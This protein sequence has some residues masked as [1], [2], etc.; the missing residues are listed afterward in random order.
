MDNTGN[1]RADV[2]GYIWMNQLMEGIDPNNPH[3]INLALVGINWEDVSGKIKSYPVHDMEDDRQKVWNW[4]NKE[5]KEWTLLPSPENFEIM[6][7]A[8]YSLRPKRKH[9]G[10]EALLE[11]QYRLGQHLEEWYGYGQNLTEGQFEELVELSERLNLINHSRAERL[12]TRLQG[13]EPVR[14]LRQSGQLVA[15]TARQTVAS[16][17]WW[18]GT[19]YELLK[20]LL[21]F[22]AT[23]K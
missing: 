21:K 1:P 22:I 11:L 14:T 5:F 10:T 2:E 17:G 15:E 19:V 4:Y 16:P 18:A 20:T 12:V 7:K 13:G 6:V 9:P 23:G 3:D 8:Y